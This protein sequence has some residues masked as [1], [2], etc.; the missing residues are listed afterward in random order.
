[1][2]RCLQLALLGQGQVAPNPMVGAVLVYE[3]R[4]IGEGYH[5]QYG[6]A[7]A[8]VNCLTSV[9]E[10]DQP[11]VPKATLYVS[12]EPCAHFGKT[13]PCVDLILEKKIQR[14]VIGSRDPFY[15]VAGKGIEKLKTA[16]IEVTV[17]VLEKECREL[18]KRFFSFYTHGRPYITLKWAESGDGKIAA[19]TRRTLISNEATNRLV[20]RWRSEETSILV[21]TNT[22]LFDDPSLTTR[23][24]PGRSPLRLVI[25]K[26]LR[27]PV[28]LQ[29]FDGEHSTVVFNALQD[30]AHFNLTYYRINGAASW[31]PQMVK[32]LS[33]MNVQSLLVEGGAILLQAFIDEGL[34]DETRV[35]TNEN[36]CI[37]KGIEA[38][39]LRNAKPFLQQKVFTDTIRYYKNAEH[40]F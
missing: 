10:E 19:H 24:W 12:L 14:V 9:R 5:Q 29:L 8:E 33:G 18:N 20:H 6:Q 15:K 25:D 35:I 28:S 27:L 17:G 4:I 39:V 11:L 37:G 13:P 22:A 38:P 34:W 21:G 40:F 26:Q 36:M 30:K 2:Q 16:G 3:D 32:A 23:L 1:M 7:H 31:V